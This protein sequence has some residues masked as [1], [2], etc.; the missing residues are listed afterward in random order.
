MKKSVNI[1][2]IKRY[3][4]TLRYLG[5]FFSHFANYELAKVKAAL[6]E[7]DVIVTWLPERFA[8]AAAKR[9]LTFVTETVIFA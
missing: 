4:K 5:A 3:K 8:T 9:L 2:F 6:F 7:V 1:S